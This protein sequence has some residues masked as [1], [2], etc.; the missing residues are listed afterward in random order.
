MEPV[1]SSETSAYNNK[2][3]PGTYPKE[4]KLQSK[5]GESLKS[6]ICYN[7]L[8]VGETCVESLVTFGEQFYYWDCCN[9][10]LLLTSHY[11]VAMCY[12]AHYCREIYG[13]EM[14]T[15]SRCG[16][17]NKCLCTCFLKDVQEFGRFLA[18]NTL[19]MEAFK[20]F[21]CTFPGFNL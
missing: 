5:H 14:G 13:E 16:A 6:R 20:L 12:I 8:S 1:E 4:K 18:F 17:L 7:L 10:R 3:T 15:G 11:I 19:R 2:L 9:V 21:K